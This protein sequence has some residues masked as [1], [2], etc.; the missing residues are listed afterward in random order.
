MPMTV[1]IL[2][3]L[4]V[5]VGVNLVLRQALL[6]ANLLALEVVLFSALLR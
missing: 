4:V 2:L 1:V 6:G 3:A 5:V